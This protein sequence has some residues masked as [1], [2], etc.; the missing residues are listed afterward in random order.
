ML[1][2]A[3]KNNKQL[4]IAYSKEDSIIIYRLILSLT[5]QSKNINTSVRK[6]LLT[7]H[8]YYK[9]YSSFSRNRLI[10][11]MTGKTRSVYRYFQLSRMKIRQQVGFGMFRGVS[12]SS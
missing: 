8:S 6:Y 4:Q 3:P 2:F 1:K 5:G 10:C 9:P 12:K 7:Y 11:S